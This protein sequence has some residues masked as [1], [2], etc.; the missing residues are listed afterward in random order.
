MTEQTDITPAP[1]KQTGTGIVALDTSGTELA[2]IF[3]GN[4]DG[5]EITAGDLTRIKIPGSGGKFWQYEDADGPQSSPTLTGVILHKQL[6]RGWWVKDLDD[7]G[8]APPACSSRDSHT[9]QINQ[10][11][12]PAGYQGPLPTGDCS[13]CPLAQ[14][15]QQAGRTPC[16]QRMQIFLLQENDF[17]PVIVD[18][19]TT[20]IKPMRRFLLQLAQRKRAFDAVVVEL[21][22][23]Q[24]KSN[25]G[26]NYS[27]VVPRT[28]RPLDPAAVEKARA[29]V[30]TLGV[31]A[32]PAPQAEV[33]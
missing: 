14:F 10:D 18:L 22:L 16:Q 33:A 2:E 30:N 28:L 15:D 25:G 1:A 24:T 3:G 17:L 23:E 21:A 27:L 20:S 11:E 6:A 19:P 9:G 29:L 32:H 5:L 13:A 8:E 7:A 4:L 31:A 12:I 26:I